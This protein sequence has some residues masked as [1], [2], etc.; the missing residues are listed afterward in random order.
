M[1]RILEIAILVAAALPLLRVAVSRA[2]WRIHPRETLSIALL[3]ASYLAA[4]AALA[5]YAPRALHIAT[6]GAAASGAWLLWRI[7]PQYG[8]R[9]G[10][11]VG[12]LFP[13]PTRPSSDPDFYLRQ[14][15]RYGSTFKTSRFGRPMI[16]IVGLERANRLL[17]EHD[18][19]LAATPLPFNRYIEGGYLRYLPEELHSAYRK[20]FHGAFHS[21][22][23]ANAE[24]GVAAAF[25]RGFERMAATSAA[26]G[27]TAVHAPVLRMMFSAWMHLFYGIGENDA[28]YARLRELFHVIDIRKARWTR[29]DRT[30][31]ALAEIE[32]ILRRRVEAM[33]D[34]E[35]TNPSSFLAALTRGDTSVLDDGTVRGNM[36]YIT[37]A[38]WGDVSGLMLWI[39]KMLGDHPEWQDRLATEPTRELAQRIVQETLR[40]EQS[41]S[42]YRRVLADFEFDGFR[43]P[44]GWLVRMCIRE[45]HR[46]DGAF[47]DANTFDPDRFA[48]R[49]YTRDE[50]AP[51]GAYRLACIGDVVTWNVGAIFALELATK[52][53][54]KVLDDG[55]AEITTWD[56]SAPNPR[57]RV[58]LEPRRTS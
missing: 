12:S 22:A 58:I 16:C 19:D 46:L 38:T 20:R 15:K 1:V 2:Y 10:L 42:R 11:P 8:V 23:L 55:P 36:I 13:L 21:D 33:T 14:A 39:F 45:S 6:V 3:G 43:I 57:L 48:R 50:Y 5:A 24:P 27:S 29:S 53:S 18:A 35:R 26:S 40:L 52:F 7:R 17:R 44:K 54:W 30:R 51:L 32:A 31:A 4:V 56:H 34:V 25:H 41:E 37:H 28:D 49:A 47:S 9:S